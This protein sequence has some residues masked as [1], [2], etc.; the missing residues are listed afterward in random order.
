M[1]LVT[2]AGLI[3][4]AALAATLVSSQAAVNPALASATP[5]QSVTL[6]V[7]ADGRVAWRLSHTTGQISRCE[8]ITGS[9]ACT[10]WSQ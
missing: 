1:N 6:G 9:I 2:S 10:P 7:S 8:Y 4:C 3:A 5:T